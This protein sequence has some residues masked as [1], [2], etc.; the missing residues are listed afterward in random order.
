[1]AAWICE[2]SGIASESY[3]IEF[4]HKNLSNIYM[5]VYNTVY[6]VMNKCCK[7]RVNH[8]CTL[9]QSVNFL[10]ECNVDTQCVI[11]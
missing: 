4:L 1:M 10:L 5:F 9:F 7:H 6:T 11:V 2:W 3:G 8:T